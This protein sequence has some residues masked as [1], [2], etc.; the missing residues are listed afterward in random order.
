MAKYNL[1]VNGKKY[2]VDADADTPLLWVIRD[3]VGLKG[4]KF[5]C[6]MALCGACT[7]HLD[8]QPVRSCST[9]ISTLKATNKITTIEGISTNTDH[10]VQKAWIEAQVPQCGYCQSGQIMSA[11]A[12]LKEKSNPTDDDIDVAMSGN[13]CRCG[14][15]PRIRQAIHRAAELMKDG[16]NS[17]GK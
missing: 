10:A 4:T 3:Y 8:G 2:N 5:G 11:V 6:G 14:T 15:Y 7:V 17:T 16:G 1:T 13:I 9:P 12:L